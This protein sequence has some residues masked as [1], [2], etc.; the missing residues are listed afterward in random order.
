M[1]FFAQKVRLWDQRQS[2][3]T[4]CIRRISVLKK[5]S[6]P[7]CSKPMITLVND[8]INFQM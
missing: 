2:A 6:G 4:S 5:R 3:L 7:S 1:L 8:S